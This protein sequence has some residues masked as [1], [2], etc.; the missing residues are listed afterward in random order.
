LT[1]G[2]TC[3]SSSATATWRTCLDRRL[4]LV[5][6]AIATSNLVDAKTL[7]VAALK[8]GQGLIVAVPRH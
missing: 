5:G 1:T 4:I 3:R 8:P 2:L 6:H 7:G